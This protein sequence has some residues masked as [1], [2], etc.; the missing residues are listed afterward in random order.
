MSEQPLSR[1][2]PIENPAPRTTFAA[3]SCVGGPV[4]KDKVWVYSGF[5]MVNEH[6]SIDAVPTA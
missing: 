5:E 2:F 1:F 6:A 4:V 3:R